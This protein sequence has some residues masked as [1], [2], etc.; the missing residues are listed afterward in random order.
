MDQQDE[1]RPRE[2]RRGDHARRPTVHSTTA[3]E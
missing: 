3:Q 1:D 2:D